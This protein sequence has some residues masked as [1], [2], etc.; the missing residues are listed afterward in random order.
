M[1]AATQGGI[2]FPPGDSDALADACAQLLLDP[3]LRRQ[4]AERGRQAVL[5]NHS[6]RVTA[7]QTLAV[8]QSLVR[9]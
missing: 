1:V 3:P 4:I 6:A 2:L 8:L 7:E 9:C 5:Q